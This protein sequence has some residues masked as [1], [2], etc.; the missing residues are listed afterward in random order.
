MG[1]IFIQKLPSDISLSVLLLL[2]AAAIIGP[3][4][5]LQ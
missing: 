1:N 2:K 5:T 4:F 3:A